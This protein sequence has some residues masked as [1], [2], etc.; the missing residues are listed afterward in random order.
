MTSSLTRGKKI[1]CSFRSDGRSA[2]IEN[3]GILQQGGVIT[4]IGKVDDLKATFTAGEVLGSDDVVIIPGL[5]NGH[6]HRGIASFQLGC[7]DSEL[8]FGW[9]HRIASRAV[10]PYLDTLCSAFGMIE[11]GVTTVQH[12]HSRH[13]GSVIEVERGSQQ[14]IQA[15]LDVGMRVS[16]SY[17]HRDQ[18]QFIYM[19]DRE[20]IGAHPEDLRGSLSEYLWGWRQSSDDYFA[21]FE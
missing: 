11:S 14:I 1:L 13:R 6:H 19:D 10:D 12:M 15:Y 8:E 18:N 3:G 2:I 9:A 20:F 21:L 5:I 7:P 16:Y 17:L 4:A